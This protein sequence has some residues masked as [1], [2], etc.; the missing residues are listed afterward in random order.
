MSLMLISKD[1]NRYKTIDGHKVSLGQYQTA[2]P[3]WLKEHVVRFI[4][5]QSPEVI[6]DPFA[7]RGLLLDAVLERI[8]ARGEGFDIDPGAGWP[9]NDSLVSIPAVPGAVIVTNPPFLAKHSA[10]RKRVHEAVSEH[11][12]SRYDLYQLALDRCI[13]A[14]PRVVAI[15][16]ETIINSPYPMRHVRSITILEDN[17]FEDT[18]CPVC[19][20]CMDALAGAP[21]GGP[22]VWLGDDLLG[23]LGRFEAMRLHP[24]GCVDIRFN[25][26]AGR[27]GLRAVDLPSPDKPAMFFARGDLD[28]P[29]ERVRESSRL[30]TFI[31][32]PSLGDEDIAGLVE[33][34]N[35]HLA[36]YR[37]ET[38][39]ILLSPFKGNT[40]EGRRR[41][42][43]D[44]RTAR[45]LLEI[46]MPTTE[47][48]LP[49]FGN[50]Y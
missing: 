43:L 12:E 4:A 2:S 7:G 16:P 47:K 44:Y 45:V 26:R 15:V 25:V 6:L 21:P 1:R 24:R 23:P 33:R 31:E 22:G 18:D 11:F 29:S 3:S 50:S 34:A 5:E 27:I 35:R 14:C 42:R 13:E 9:V 41:R 40:K 39:D 8:P 19:V 38:H 28:Y 48:E 36:E 17:P 46:A 32:I 30:V 49:L 20:I 37:R 10:R